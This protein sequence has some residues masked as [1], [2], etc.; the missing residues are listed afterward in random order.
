MDN[1][2][3]NTVRDF[4]AGVNKNLCRQRTDDYQM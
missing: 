3:R 2:K 1:R 4:G